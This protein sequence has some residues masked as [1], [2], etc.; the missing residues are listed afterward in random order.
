ML[1][2]H[3]CSTGQY[4]RKLPGSVLFL[5]LALTQPGIPAAGEF[6]PS[7]YKGSVLYVDFWASWCAPCRAS[8]P[9]MNKMHQ[10]YAAD[11]LVIV[12]INTG[13]QE[14]DRLKFLATIPAEFEIVTDDSGDLAARFDLKGMPMS[15]LYNRAGERVATHIGFNNKSAPEVQAEIEQLLLEDN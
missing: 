9:W 5:L 15:F 8:F 14:P 1:P 3:K 13:D 4:L 2:A 12:A 11:G 7:Q 6:D 10:A